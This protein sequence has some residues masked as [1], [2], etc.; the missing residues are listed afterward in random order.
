MDT[1]RP[2]P[3]YADIDVWDPADILDAMLEGQFAAVAAVRAVLDAIERAAAAI[4]GRLSQGGRLV[5]AGAGTSGR[6]AVQDGAELM[7]TFNWPPRAPAA[8]DRR[9]RSGHD[10]G[11]RGRRGRARAG[12]RPDTAPRHQLQRRPGRGGRQ[13]HHPVYRHVHARRQGPRRPDGRHR[14]QRRHA[15]PHRGRPRH[16]PADARRADCRLDPHECR[17]RAAR[18]PQPAVDAGHDPARPRV[19]RLDGRR[20]GHQPQAHQTQ[21]GDA[22]LPDR[23]QP[24]GGAERPSPPPTATSSSPCCCCTA[25]T[26]SAHARC[27]PKPTGG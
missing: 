17:H 3:R 26:P 14:Q 7:P 23:P 16:L 12:R 6:L 4:E 15:P 9:R 5:Y 1:E 21:G 8:A 27:W 11:G 18:H 25:A 20:A 22:G 13:R 2:S 19:P 24:R 10:P